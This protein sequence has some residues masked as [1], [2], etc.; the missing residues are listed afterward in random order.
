MGGI[1]EGSVGDN[2]NDDATESSS[3]EDEGAYPGKAK[4]AIISGG[5]S[6]HNSEGWCALSTLHGSTIWMS[7]R[8]GQVGFIEIRLRYSVVAYGPSGR[9]R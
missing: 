1:D 3:E 8:M 5:L 6:G 2:A 9:R 4:L 7:V